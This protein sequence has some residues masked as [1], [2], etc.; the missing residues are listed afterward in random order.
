MFSGQRTKLKKVH[1]LILFLSQGNREWTMSPFP[2]LHLSLTVGTVTAAKGESW[3]ITCPSFLCTHRST[4]KAQWKLLLKLQHNTNTAS[5]KEHYQTS[6]S[7][8]WYCWDLFSNSSRIYFPISILCS[9]LKNNIDSQP[10]EA[11][12]SSERT[13]VS[14]KP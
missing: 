12:F 8:S 10:W 11:N 1:V 6:V 4:D 7:K 13:L 5:C 9:C 14:Y 3:N 2:L